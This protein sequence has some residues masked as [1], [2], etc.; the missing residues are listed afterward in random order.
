MIKKALLLFAVALL[1]LASCTT[2]EA[3][4]PETN[5]S[6]YSL[7]DLAEITEQAAENGTKEDFESLLQES[8]S[9][10]GDPCVNVTSRYIYSVIPTRTGSVVT[11]YYPNGAFFTRFT[12]D[13]ELGE[14]FCQI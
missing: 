13:N 6:E 11:A 10:R 9:H 14:W 4:E 7:D 8:L 12:V 3:F 5:K 2:E 1:T